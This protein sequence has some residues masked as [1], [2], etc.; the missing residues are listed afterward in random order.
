MSRTPPT[1]VVCPRC[2][3]TVGAEQS[4]CLSCGAPARTR[5]RPTP[6]WRLPVA[7]VAAVVLIVAG[8]TLGAFVALTTTGDDP[9]PAATTTVAPVAPAVPEPDPQPT[10]PAVTPTTPTTATTATTTSTPAAPSGGTAVPGTTTAPGITTAPAQPGAGT[11]TT[12]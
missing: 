4:W 9:V 10:A 12:P 3:N 5:M 2:G 11:A 6:N 1:P 7:T 8:G